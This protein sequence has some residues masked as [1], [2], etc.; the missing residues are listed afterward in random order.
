MRCLLT[1]VLLPLRISVLVKMLPI[2]LYARIGTTATL[3]C[4]IQYRGYAWSTINI[5][6]QNTTDS[7]LLLNVSSDETVETEN[8][9]ISASVNRDNDYINMT[10]SF[11]MSP[12]SGVCELNQTYSCDIQLMDS[13]IGTIAAD[14]LFILESKYEYTMRRMFNTSYFLYTF[15]H[16][17]K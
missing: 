6:Q 4:S 2:V 14:T 16:L 17:M 1:L 15:F 3:I 8:S 7:V 9:R 10:V 5:V 11:D 13:Y 12:G